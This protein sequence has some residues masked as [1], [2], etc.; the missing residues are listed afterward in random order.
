MLLSFGSILA[1]EDSEIGTIRPPVSA[2][3]ERLYTYDPIMDRYIFTEE[4]L[5]LI[6]I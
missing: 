4:I 6:H 5:S 1:Q 2:S 3:I